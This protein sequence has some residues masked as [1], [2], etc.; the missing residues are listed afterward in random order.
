MHPPRKTFTALTRIALLFSFF[1][2]TLFSIISVL[3]SSIAQTNEERVFEDTTPKHLPIKVKVKKEKEKAFKDL[4]NEKWMRD[5]ELEVTNTGNKPIYFLYFVVTLSDTTAPN[6]TNIAFPLMYGRAE[7]GNI[8]NKATPDDVPIKPGET[9]V[10]KAYDGNVRGWD[11]F[12]RNHNKPQP[13]KLIFRF[14]IL[15]FGDGT[16]FE[17]TGGLPVPEPPKERSSLGR[18]EQEQNKGAPKAIEGRRTISGNWPATFSA[19]I[20]PA[21]FLLANFFIPESSKSA[22]TIGAGRVEDTVGVGRCEPCSR[23]QGVEAG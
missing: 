21:S 9:Y 16:G 13:K 15:S 1:G 20:L 11:L 7:L 3:P 4:K 23:L 2:L 6:G 18:C 5:F 14:Q 10:L 22:S 19:D 12:R 8:E 17:S